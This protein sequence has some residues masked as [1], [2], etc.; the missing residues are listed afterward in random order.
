M[1]LL[2]NRKENL[3]FCLKQ[4]QVTPKEVREANNFSLEYLKKQIHLIFIVKKM[5][6]R[7]N[8]PPYSNQQQ[9]Y[10]NN[11]INRVPITQHNAYNYQGINNVPGQQ[12]RYISMN[13]QPSSQNYQQRQYY[14]Q[15]TVNQQQIQ[16]QQQRQQAFSQKTISS[17]GFKRLLKTKYIM[18]NEIG[19]GSFAKVFKGINSETGE[20]VAIKKIDKNKFDKQYLE[21]I[22][23]EISVLSQLNNEHIIKFL[24][25]FNEGDY[26]YIVT[27]L[28]ELGDLE[29]FIKN[30]FSATKLRLPEELVKVFAYQIL[31]AFLGIADMNIIHRDMKLANVLITKDFHLKVADFG[32]AKSSFEKDKDQVG[33]PMTMAPEVLNNL[34][35]DSRCDV[36]SVGCMIYEMLEGRAPFLPT[37]N[38]GIE[39]LKRLIN[40]RQLIFRQNISQSAQ[41]L[42]DQML[43]LNPKKRISW[44]E[45]FNH[46]WFAECI[47]QG[48]PYIQKVSKDYSNFVLIEEQHLDPEFAL[49]FGLLLRDFVNYHVDTFYI[50]I[51]KCRDTLSTFYNDPKFPAG[52]KGANQQ[53]LSTVLKNIDILIALLY[54]HQ[55][56]FKFK[57]QVEILQI[58]KFCKQKMQLQYKKDLYEF[59]IN[60]NI[61]PVKLQETIGNEL[62]QLSNNVMEGDFDYFKCNFTSIINLINVL[63]NPTKGF[64]KEIIIDESRL[65]EE[66]NNRILFINFSKAYYEEFNSQQEINKQIVFNRTFIQ[67][68]FQEK[69]QNRYDQIVLLSEIVFGYQQEVISHNSQIQQQQQYQQDKGNRIRDYQQN[70]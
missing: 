60:N 20:K 22:D 46:E 12:N 6:Q 23:S 19:K 16:Q 44:H 14:Q 18:A 10:N 37:N 11:T 41:N 9:Y 48:E 2:Y 39:E 57:N 28:C 56:T 67:T 59:A 25:L 47:S 65:T 52:N 27:E 69:E 21:L 49:E 13:Q 63:S 33:T 38:G 35:Y 7:Y 36:W 3:K 51:K 50:E 34:G 15:P 61:K 26:I 45:M 42:I 32:L 64:L 66:Q 8:N 43:T 53:L 30:N 54:N 68:Q 31:L 55:F 4:P 40:Q 58:T 17:E 29:V 70:Y 5:D 24:D 1:R 62:F